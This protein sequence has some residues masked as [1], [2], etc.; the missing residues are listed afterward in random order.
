MDNKQLTPDNHLHD[1]LALTVV[2]AEQTALEEDDE[3][4]TTQEGDEQTT[5]EQNVE[6][7]TEQSTETIE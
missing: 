6:R 7:T 2:A 5:A 4:A 1:S 3:Q